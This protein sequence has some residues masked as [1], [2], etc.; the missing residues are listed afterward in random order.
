MC[1]RDRHSTPPATRAPP[2]PPPLPPSARPPLFVP[3]PRSASCP[4]AGSTRALSV[5]DSARRTAKPNT[6]NR[7]PE[8]HLHCD[9][10][11][12]K[13][14][15]TRLR[16]A[17]NGSSAAINGSVAS[18]NGSVASI[19]GSTSN[20]HGQARQH[21]TDWVAV[22][23]LASAFQVAGCQWQLAR[24]P[25]LF[26]PLEVGAEWPMSEP[27]VLLHWQ[28][29]AQLMCC[30]A[31][32]LVASYAMCGSTTCYMHSLAPPGQYRTLLRSKRVGRCSRKTLGQYRTSHS[33][34]VGR[35]CRTGP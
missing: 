8:T 13:G 1:I 25:G 9:A 6:R 24:G 29:V 27:R 18:I 26:L 16:N 32:V 21:E 34:R 30:P 7:I 20:A 31:T 11:S 17:T 15:R 14:G 33:R 35:R 19:N 12:K 5:L 2:P 22:W 28:V 3:P 10:H 4:R 23:H